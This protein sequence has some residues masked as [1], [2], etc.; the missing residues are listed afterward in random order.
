MCREAWGTPFL[1]LGAQPSFLSAMYKVPGIVNDSKPVWTLQLASC[2]IY[3]T[4]LAPAN[5]VPTHPSLPPVFRLIRQGC[6][7]LSPT[8]LATSCSPKTIAKVLNTFSYIN[9]STVYDITT[10]L[11]LIAGMRTAGKQK[12]KNSFVLAI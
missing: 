11:V 9:F 4:L 12:P 5:W 10:T 3:P 7:Q 2:L 6:D 1:A 8:K